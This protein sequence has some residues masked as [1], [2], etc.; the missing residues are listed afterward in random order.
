MAPFMA[1]FVIRV[2]WEL[3]TWSADKVTTILIANIQPLVLFS[4]SVPVKCS[5]CRMK[6]LWL[7]FLMLLVPPGPSAEDGIGPKETK[8]KKAKLPKM[9][10]EDNLLVLKKSN[11]DRALKE[12]KYLL[13]EFCEYE[14]RLCSILMALQEHYTDD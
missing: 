8:P 10:E 7:S 3:A 5:R 9:K 1:G 12:T 4:H 13:V 11:F 2:M 14:W 6:T